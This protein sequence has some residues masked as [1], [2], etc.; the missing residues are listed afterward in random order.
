MLEV[1][2]YNTCDAV[3]FSKVKGRYGIYSNMADNMSLFVN[4]V[5][6]PSS[7]ALYQACK[8]PL[9]PSIQ[10]EILCQKNAMLAKKVAR[11]Y[12]S[13]VRQDW[14][15]IRFRVMRWCLHIKLL[16]NWNIFA[17]ELMASGNRPIVECSTKDSVWGAMPNNDGTLTGVNALGRLLMELR[18]EICLNYPLKRVLPPK[19]DGF[20]LYGNKIETAYAPEILLAD[21]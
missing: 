3:T 5:N 20:L 16:Q 15:D 17:A 10:H 11:K 14:I 7:E 19:I 4:D 6:I 21:L 1:R 13:F 8:F 12:E 2:T 18:M 9:F